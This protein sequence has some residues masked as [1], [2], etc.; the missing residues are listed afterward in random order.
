M[1]AKTIIDSD[2]FLDMP[3]TSQLL[4][5]HLSMR[6]DDD[7]FVNKPKS[8]MRMVGCKEDDLKL[9]FVKKFLIPFDS[10]VVVIKHWKIHN[11][12]RKDTY[13]E[14]KYKE[15]KSALELDENSAYR[16]SVTNPLQLRDE[17]VTGTSTQDRLGKVRSGKDRLNIEEEAPEA[18]PP[19]PKRHKYGAYQNV[20]LSDEEYEKLRNEFPHDYSER[21]ERLSEYI[22][23]TGK[24]YKNHLATIRSWA[25]KD[26]DKRK[27]E[28]GKSGNVFLEM[29]QERN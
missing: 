11:Y 18:A 20:L 23:S 21:I 12:I 7:G 24:T 1:F 2:A 13:T 16:L 3:V 5:F 10:G 4:Y 8:V 14:T 19:K 17:S 6:A 29:L 27:T 28:N 22:A 26:A 15:E 25:R 9:L